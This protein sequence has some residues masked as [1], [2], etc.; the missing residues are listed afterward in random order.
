MTRRFLAA[1][2]LAVCSPALAQDWSTYFNMATFGAG[3]GDASSGSI[4]LECGDAQSG[5][6][7]PGQ[8]YLLVSPATDAHLNKKLLPANVRFSIGEETFHIPMALEPGGS[9]LGNV[10]EET[11]EETA[12][13]FVSALRE[14]NELEIGLEEVSIARIGLRGSGEALE[15]IDSCLGPIETDQV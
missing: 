5:A 9:S 14:G 12:R 15:A 6:H 11:S 7:N 13:N 4:S 3:A 10:R 1:V 2:M 8:L